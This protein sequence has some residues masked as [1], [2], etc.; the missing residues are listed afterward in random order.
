MKNSSDKPQSM[1]TPKVLR[2]WIW[3]QIWVHVLCGICTLSFI[4][5]FLNRENKDKKIQAWS[6]RLLGIF[7]IELEVLDARLLGS[8]P[9]LIASNHISWLDIHVINAFKPIRFVAKSEVASWPIFGW[10]ATQLGTVFIRRDSARHARLVVAHMADVLKTQSICIF[11][12]G[13][14]TNGSTVLPFKPNLFESAIVAQTPVCPI[15]IQYISKITG[16][17]SESPAFVGDMGLL[18]SMS[19]VI[20]DRS[21]LA[22][23]TILTPCFPGSSS[24]LDRKKLANTCQESIAKTL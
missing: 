11:P 7:N 20:K 24:H 8:T 3:V 5:P 22:K 15:A 14:S 21:L 16:V 4:I 2:I 6:K 17:M 9:H 10:M 23:I 12:E 19:K 13:T 18:E 1:M